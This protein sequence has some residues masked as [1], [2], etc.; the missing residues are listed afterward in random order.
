MQFAGYLSL[1][2]IFWQQLKTISKYATRGSLGLIT[3]SYPT[4]TFRE[5]SLTLSTLLD[6]HAKPIIKSEYLT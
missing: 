5:L 2:R 6:L 4:S 1:R 3:N